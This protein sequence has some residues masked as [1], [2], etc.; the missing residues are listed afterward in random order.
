MATKIDKWGNSHAVRIPSQALKGAR[1]RRG[2]PVQVRV[3]DEGILISRV[4]TNKPSRGK[5][6]YKLADLLAMNKRPNP[7]KNIGGGPPAG[8]EI[9]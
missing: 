5:R 9:L 1:L 4:P 8:R 2:T 6:K 7:Y 3:V